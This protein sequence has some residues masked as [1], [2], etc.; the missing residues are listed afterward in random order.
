MLAMAD[1]RLGVSVVEPNVDGVNAPTGMALN[2]AN[3]AIRKISRRSHTN[4]ATTHIAQLLAESRCA[5]PYFD[6]LYVLDI[7]SPRRP[8]MSISEKH[9][10]RSNPEIARRLKRAA[11][12]HKSV[13]KMIE[14][15]RGS[16]DIAQQLHAVE[17][18]VG[19]AKRALIRDH[20]DNCLEDAVGP[21]PKDRR[22]ST[23]EFKQI[24][25]Y[26]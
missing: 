7:S 11:G 26:L 22:A 19:E 12:H 21:S 24:A 15:H 13:I 17:K 4:V 5:N 16:L 14:G 6:V 8:G 9:I 18:P 2:R 3:P 20:L 23:D 1:C 10:H 25:K